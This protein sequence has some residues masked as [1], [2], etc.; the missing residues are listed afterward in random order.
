MPQLAVAFGAAPDLVH[1]MTH[2]S[3][4]PWLIGGLAAM[5]AT[6][7]IGLLARTWALRYRA[8]LLVSV[9]GIA[10]VATILPGLPAQSVGLA[11]TGSCHAIAY[12][13]LLIWFTTSLRPNRE[14]VVT[15]FARR[16]RLTMPDKVVRYTRYLTIAWSAFFAAQLALS[17]MLPLVASAA[18]WVAFVNLLNL[19][20][21]VAMMLAE[22]ACRRILFRHEPRT[23]LSETLTAMRH[24]RFTPAS[25]P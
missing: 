13:S 2:G 8:T 14:P 19:P 21:V 20:L 24:A 3:V 4:A 25:R 15:G 18:V 1:R 16:V 22:F 23:G 9:L 7:L 5:Q 11:M 6:A 17:A 10:A 12:I